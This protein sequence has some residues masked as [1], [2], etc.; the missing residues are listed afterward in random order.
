M[1]LLVCGG[2][3]FNDYE[4]L[5]EAMR[6]LPFTPSIIVEGGARGADSLA[7]GWAVENGIHYAEVPALWNN[8]DK[9]AGGLRNSAMLLLRPGYCL[10][11]PGGSGTWNMINQCINENITVWEPYK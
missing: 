3:G 1:I 2:R 4:K 10:A 5:A 11:M 9:A 7:R 8:F 6:L